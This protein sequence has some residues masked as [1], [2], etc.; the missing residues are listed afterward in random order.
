MTHRYH[1]SN[2]IRITKYCKGNNV[3]KIKLMCIH[4]SDKN[5]ITLQICTIDTNIL[6][7]K[8]YGE[9]SSSSSP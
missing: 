8:V 5:D 1:L 6:L 9:L 3:N 2:H 7:H 4:Y